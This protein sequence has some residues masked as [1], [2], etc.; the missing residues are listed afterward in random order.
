MTVQFTELR[1]GDGGKGG[2]AADGQS[3]SS[4]SFFF[5]KHHNSFPLVFIQGGTGLHLEACLR[6]IFFNGRIKKKKEEKEEEL[7][8]RTE[9]V[10]TQTTN[11]KRAQE[12]EEVEEEMEEK[13]GLVLLPFSNLFIHLYL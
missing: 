7:K 12:P 5:L 9:E 8:I 3:V 13:E 4:L 10:S 11:M 2:N 1:S 6:N